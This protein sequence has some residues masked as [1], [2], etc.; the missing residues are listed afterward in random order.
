[1][2]RL[3]WSP[4][5]LLTVVGVALCVPMLW[6]QSAA[7]PRATTTSDNALLAEV[8][9]LRADLAVASRASLR[10]Q[11]LLARVQLQEQ[12]IIYLDRRR[13][14]AAARATDT[15]EKARQAAARVT[16]LDENLRRFKAMGIPREQREGMV[17]QIAFELEKARAD[18]VAAAAAEQSVRT[19]EADLVG[20][21]STEQGRWNEFNARLDELE[22]SL[23][24]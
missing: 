17:A 5:A 3:P 9:A 2:R 10:A 6:A 23:P 12:R 14:D 22:R 1:M 16:E 13:V 8:R 21:L 19:E 7:A 20:A 11:M 18:A 15:A 24:K 4:P